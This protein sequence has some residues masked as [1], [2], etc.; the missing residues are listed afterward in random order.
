MKTIVVMIAM[1][2][3]GHAQ[4]WDCKYERT[5]EK[6]LDLADSQ[7]L[8]VIAAAGDLEITGSSGSQSALVRGRVCASEESWIDEAD[9]LTRG[10]DDAEIAVSLPKHENTWSFIGSK[11]VYMDLVITV[12]DDIP[13]Q[14]SDSSGDAKIIGVAE[15]SVSDSSGDLDIEDINGSVAV[16]DSSGDIDLYD[17]AGDV[18]VHNDSSGDIDG[19]DILGSVLIEKDSSGDIHFQDVRDNFTVERDSSGDIVADTVGGD[20][21][22]LRDGSGEIRTKRVSGT[23]ELPD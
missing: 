11:Y 22:V 5:I 14:V 2:V 7:Q 13:M 21:R 4:A 6:S 12:P 23:V 17:I 15:L 16:R 8:S 10:G 3:A 1:L 18:V 19:R 20:F 9:I